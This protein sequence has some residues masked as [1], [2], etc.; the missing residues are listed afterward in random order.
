MVTT[1]IIALGGGGFSEEPG[2]PLLDLYVLQAA[3]KKSPK[4]CFLPTASG[5]AEGYIEK[6]HA[7]FKGYEC[8]P[9]HLSLFKPHTADIMDFLLSQDILYVGGG[10]TKSM[11]ALW[12]EWKIDAALKDALGQG[13]VLAGISAG[14]ICWFEEGATDSIPGRISVLPCLG[15]LPGSCCPHFDAEPLRRETVPRLI[16]EGTMKPGYAIDNSAAL[17]F[18]DGSLKA[19]VCSIPGKGTTHLVHNRSIR[20]A[21]NLIAIQ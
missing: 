18:V 11:L 15:F 19:C 21:S 20:L 1:Q 5:D 2:N 7:C 13:I 3:K 4:I 16:K 17:H 10:N 12:R 14:A 9:S 6:F 8:V